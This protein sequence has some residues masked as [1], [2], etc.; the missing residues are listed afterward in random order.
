VADLTYAEVGATLAAELPAGYH[1]LDVRR[2]VGPGDA[3]DEL[4]AF[5]AGWGLQRGAGLKVPVATVEEGA[6]LT[7]RLGL[8]AIP[9]R[10][11]RVLAEEDRRGFVYGTL[12]GHPETGEEAFLAE[13][14]ED[15]TWVRVRAFSR[16]GTWW[17]RLGAP[18]TALMQRRYTERYLRA[19]QDAV[20]PAAP[21]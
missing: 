13:R 14:D 2:R 8:V 15:G 6:E 11:L 4:G 17:S 20:T 7:L 19:A 16:P 9:V 5:I 10:V 1:H 18:V 12:R 21:G 3:L